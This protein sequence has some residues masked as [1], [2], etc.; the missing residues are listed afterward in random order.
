MPV[1]LVI[2]GHFCGWDWISGGPSKYTYEQ[3][4]VPLTA[5]AALVFLVRAAVARSRLCLL[6]GVQ[7]AVFC[8]REI[9]FTGTHRGVY[10]A[11]AAVGVWAL[12]WAWRYRDR[13]RPEAV[14]WRQVSFLAAAVSAY[15][16]AIIIQ[17]RVFKGIPGEQTLHVPLEEATEMMAHILLVLGAM[18]GRWRRGLSRG[19]GREQE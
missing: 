15:A 13:L 17:K 5:L 6:A 8:C 16:L 1:A 4:A 2:G 9:H 10:V 14:D 18:V 3:P 19:G 11:T 12:A 7:A